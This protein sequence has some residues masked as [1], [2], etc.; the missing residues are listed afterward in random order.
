MPKSQPRWLEWRNPVF[1]EFKIFTYISKDLLKLE[2]FSCKCC[3][4]RKMN[5]YWNG[6][7]ETL[8]LAACPCRR[9]SSH[10]LLSWE[11]VFWIWTNHNQHDLRVS[12]QALNLSQSQSQ[13][14]FALMTPVQ[15]SSACWC[16]PTGWIG[17]LA[18]AAANSSS[19]SSLCFRF[20][21]PSPGLH[22]CHVYLFL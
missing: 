20:S 15:S 6:A 8:Q 9:R 7:E 16:L 1:V 22:R 12:V 2:L 3:A 18:A 5:V 21:L 19:S 11:F 14:L 10:S 17:V 13:T 4:T